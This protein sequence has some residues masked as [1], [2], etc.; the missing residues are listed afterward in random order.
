MSK[1][2]KTVALSLFTAA[3]ALAMT[4]GAQAGPDK[5]KKNKAAATAA[6]A[7]DIP[8]PTIDSNGDGKADPNQIDDAALGAANLLCFG[9]RDLSNPD[10]WE[11]AIL[12]YNQSREYL[13][14]VAHAANAYSVPQPAR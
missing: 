10:Q 14:K 7:A 13:D 6:P 4:T 9:D 3:A 1:S 2:V 11:E 12:N 5:E 8:A